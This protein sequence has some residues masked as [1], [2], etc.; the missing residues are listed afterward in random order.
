[1]TISNFFGTAD[2]IVETLHDGFS[3]EQASYRRNGQLSSL[4]NAVAT[5][6]WSYDIRGFATNVQSTVGSLQSAV[7]YRH[8]AVGN[9]TGVLWNVGSGT[10]DVAYGYD[11]AER[12]SVITPNPSRSLQLPGPFTLSYNDYNGLLNTLS[13]DNIKVDYTFDVL[14]AVINAVYRDGSGDAL[15]SF[16]YKHDTLGLITQKVAVVDGTAIT[17]S[18]TYDNLGRLTSELSLPNPS[19]SPAPILYTY[20]LAGNRLSAGGSSYTYTHNKLDG[21]LHDASGNITNMVQNGVTLDLAWNS[22]GQLTSVST[23]GVFAESY[24]WGPLGN[25]LSTSNVSGIVYHV[26][27]GDHCIADADANGG[28]IASYTWGTGIDNL[29]AVTVYCD[30]ATNTYYAVKDHLNSV[31]ALI[32]ESGNTVMSV[33]Y[34]A[35]GTP[36]NSSLSIQNS[37]FQL[38]YLF[39]GRERSLA[40]GLYNFRARWYSSDI[41][42]WL[43]K[44]PIGL[45]GGLNLYV[46]CGNNPVNFVDP[47]GFQRGYMGGSGDSYYPD[48]NGHG[49]LPNGKPKDPHVDRYFK[50]GGNAQYNPNATPRSGSPS[51]PKKDLK[52]YNRALAKIASI[53]SRYNL[54][55]ML[56]F[57]PYDF[58]YPQRPLTKP[59]SDGSASPP[60]YIIDTKNLKKDDSGNLV[61][62]QYVLDNIYA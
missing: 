38:R 48:I 14:D 42:R 5:L 15:A 34:N 28:L 55:I 53:M 47:W 22:Q 57:T 26:Y 24:T 17:N 52:A 32:D 20:D 7:C 61:P 54:P 8:D 49:K 31:H 1:M 11:E 46:F 9:T 3:I 39:Q 30:T 36:L 10:L 37:S 16:S 12:L 50:R 18:Y 59:M 40:T 41:G 44:D 25:R 19:N 35:W 43:S 13:N 6:G 45:E 21:V 2:D 51:V 23:N 58:P 33:A 4:S 62:Y 56:I 27:N 29:L 60:G